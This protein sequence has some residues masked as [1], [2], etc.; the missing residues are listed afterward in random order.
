MPG[1]VRIYSVP[2]G[3][4][5]TRCKGPN[6]GKLVYWIRTPNGRPLLV[7]CDVEGG[8]R[9]SEARDPKQL[10]LLSA[11]TDVREGFGVSHFT[12]CPDAERFS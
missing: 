9:P 8:T 11:T 4:K 10:S 12:N 6:C 3:T 7:D 5:P 1:T 2:P